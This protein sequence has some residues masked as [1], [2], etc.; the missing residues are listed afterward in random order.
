MQKDFPELSEEELMA[1]LPLSLEELRTDRRYGRVFVY[2]D[3]NTIA[4]YSQF[5]A[6][7]SLSLSLSLVSLSLCSLP[8]GSSHLVAVQEHRALLSAYSKLRSILVNE[9]YLR[10]SP[11][12]VSV[13][14]FLSFLSLSL[15]CVI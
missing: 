11:S 3:K 13:S 6:P 15:P 14:L 10:G 9:R 8:R 7:A 5:Q 1:P 2:D 4:R 12:D